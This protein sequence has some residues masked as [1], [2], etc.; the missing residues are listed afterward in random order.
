[1]TMVLVAVAMVAIIAMAALSIDVVTLYLAREEAQ[2]SADAA[3]LAGA[4]ILSLTG[5]TGDPANTPMGTPSTA[6]WL[7]ACTLASQVAQ[8]VANQNSVNSIAAAPTVTFLYNGTSVGDCS[9]VSPTSGFSLNPQVQVQVVRNGLPTLFS[10]VWG[11]GAHSISATATAE[12]FNPSSSG[13]FA[14]GGI[15]PVAPRCVKPWIIPNMD[16]AGG[17]AALVNTATGSIVT[18]GIELGGAG[19]GIIGENFTLTNACSGANCRNAR[20]SSATAG[21]YVPALIGTTP[22]PTAIPS[23]ATGDDFQEAVGG[24]D[25][26]TPYACGTLDGSQMDFSINPSTDTDTAVNCL[27]RSS[28]PDVIDTSSFPFQIKA[29][30]SNPTGLT[31]QPITASTSIVTLPIF[32][33]GSTGGKWPGGFR[34]NHPQT[35]IVGFMQVFI[36]ADNGGGNMNVH[37]L[38]ISGCSNSATSTAVLGTSPVPIRLITPP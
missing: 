33:S 5:V 17:G 10:R 16:P 9:G 28:G 37:V 18:Q 6:P 29:G 20:G 23:C 34:N 32:D 7:S 38:N 11:R 26:S 4:R 3:A 8:A 36:D 22:A 19:T 21:S 12:A 15:V 24:C 2:R 31:S 13:T 30:P 27:I 14:S 35:T 25:Q 1:M